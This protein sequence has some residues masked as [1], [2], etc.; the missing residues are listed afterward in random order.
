M[1]YRTV[2]G[3]TRLVGGSVDG[4]LGLLAPA[5]GASAPGAERDA[6]VAA[7]NGVLG[8]YLA[9]TGNP[10]GTPLELTMQGPATV[11]WISAPVLAAKPCCWAR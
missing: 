8:D 7:L 10:L 2:R 9:T 11:W 1:V 5:L 4:L 3:V 6:L